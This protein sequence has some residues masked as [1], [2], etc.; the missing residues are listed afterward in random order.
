MKDQV[1]FSFLCK[2]SWFE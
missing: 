2:F 1:V